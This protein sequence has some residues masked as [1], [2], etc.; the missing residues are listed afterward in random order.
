MKNALF[1]P[2]NMED[3]PAIKA[4][5]NNTKFAWLWLIVRVYLGYQWIHSALG[6]FE[7]LGHRQGTERVFRAVVNNKSAFKVVIRWPDMIS[8]AICYD[9]TLK[10]MIKV[11]FDDLPVLVDPVEAMSRLLLRHV[12][13]KRAVIVPI[14]QQLP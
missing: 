5:F 8:P 12:S 10:N 9:T 6:K 11:I 14:E 7:D 4:L 2:H 3:A 13:V 1:G